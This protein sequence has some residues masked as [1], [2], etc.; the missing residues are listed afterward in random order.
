M[1]P[2]RCS[3]ARKS[4]LIVTP[5]LAA[6]NNGNWRTAD[7][8]AHFLA[9]L[10]NTDVT[11]HWSPGEAEPDLM[12]ALHARRSADDIARFSATGKPTILVLTGTDL[13]RDIRTDAAA[14]N[15]LDLARRLV[16]L[17]PAGLDELSPA[18][19]DKCVVIEQSAPS[20][21]AIAPRPDTF[22]LLLVGHLRVE[23]DPLTAARALQHLPDKSICLRAVG[24]SDDAL[25][26]RPFAQMAAADPRIEL[27][28]EQSH[29]ATRD[30]I[31]QGRLLLLP[32]LMEGGAN[33]LIEAVVSDT[34][35]LASHISGSVGM[36]GAD[37]PGYFPVGD[38]R[39]LAGLIR[40]CMS[41]PAFIETLRAHCRA[42]TPLF[43]PEREA[44]L[45]RETVSQ[46]VHA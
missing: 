11:R 41:E 4:I 28:G 20:M 45:V 17:Q 3:S 21:P 36:L 16:V 34:P 31:R 37:Y 27:L 44:R 6:A 46:L 8:W 15:S 7:R 1:N 5:A 33:V 24:R 35:V 25:T 22:D 43:A 38:D 42:R 14:I 10:Y 18:A 19:R 13:Y 40:R 30:L 12:I 9:D 29:A 26:G 39:A 23:K 32:S 2:N